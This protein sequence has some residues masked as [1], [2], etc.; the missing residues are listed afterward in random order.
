VEIRGLLTNDGTLIAEGSM[1]LGPHR[2]NAPV[3]RTI[4]LQ[5]DVPAQRLPGWGRLHLIAVDAEGREIEHIDS[6]VQLSNR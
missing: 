2:G 1:A 5:L 6:N 4:G 3:P